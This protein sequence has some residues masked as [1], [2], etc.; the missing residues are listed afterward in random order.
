MFLILTCNTTYL[1]N[2]TS[3]WAGDTLRTCQAKGD[4]EEKAFNEEDKILAALE[5]A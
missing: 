1:I 4:V 5:K 3:L 2:P